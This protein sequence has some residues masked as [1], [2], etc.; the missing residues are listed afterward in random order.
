M[1]KHLFPYLFI[2]AGV[3]GLLMAFTFVNA[4]ASIGC[5][6]DTN[7]HPFET[8]ICWLHDH[9]ITS[10][11]PDGS[12]KPS[13]FITRG[14][15]AVFLSR[16]ITKGD[17]Y[18]NTGPGAWV[19][20]AYTPNAYVNYY[21]GWSHLANKAPGASTNLFFISPSVPSS[22]YNTEMLIKGVKFCYDAT[23]GAS[24]TNLYLVHMTYSGSG[25]VVYNSATDSTVRNDVGCATLYFATPSPFWG[26]DQVSFSVTVD[27]LG[28]STPTSN[29][30]KVG[31]VTIILEPTM[32][33]GVLAPV[34]GMPEPLVPTV[35]DPAS[36]E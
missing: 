29:I 9:G 7:G 11:Y 5:F 33:P 19:P 26:P 4:Y 17:I 22:L 10:G 16:V 28:T 21:Y 20:N 8:Y 34:P 2:A 36:G 3:L 1:K 15:M 27:F 30:V 24:I 35:Y 23:W 18:I 32:D 31:V 12:F 13:N 14:E 6:T 25:M